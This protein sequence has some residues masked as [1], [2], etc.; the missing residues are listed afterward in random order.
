M[1]EIVADPLGLLIEFG[2]EGVV[3]SGVGGIGG[4]CGSLVEGGFQLC[5]L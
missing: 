4:I 3:G 1:R 2:D 5:N